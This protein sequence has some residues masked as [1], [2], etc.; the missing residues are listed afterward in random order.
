MVV[1]VAR[2]LERDEIQSSYHLVLYV[3]T[4]LL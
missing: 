1:R 4:Y 2:I 3:Y